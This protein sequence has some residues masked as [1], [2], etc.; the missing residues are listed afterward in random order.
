MAEEIINRVAN[1]SLTS[2]DLEDLWDDRDRAQ[3]DFNE[4]LF[5]GM[6]LREKDFR[7][8]VKTHDWTQYTDKNVAIFCS[9]D[10]LIPSWAY[11]IVTANLEPFANTTVVGSQDELTLQ[12]YKNA[13]EQMDFEQYRDGKVVIKGCSSKSVPASVYAEITRRLR[14]VASSIMYGEPC[15]TVPV[16]K[17]P[18]K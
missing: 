14:S 9:T 5:E 15:S 1:S 4:L 12:L 13:F 11:M 7:E 8:F 17:K 6:I 10:A 18:R 2:F 3:I 16:F